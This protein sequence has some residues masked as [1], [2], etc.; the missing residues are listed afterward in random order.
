MIN[1]LNDLIESNIFS[2]SSFDK[3][4]STEE[5]Q[6][7]KITVENCSVAYLSGYLSHMCNKKF[8]CNNCLNTLIFI[9][10]K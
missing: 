2:S 10:N 6:S 5:T 8:D 4:N 7:D 3:L 9:L 1:D